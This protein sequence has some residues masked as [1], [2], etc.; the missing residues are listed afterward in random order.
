[1]PVEKH[2]LYSPSSSYLWGNCPAHILLKPKGASDD[3]EASRD[4]TRRHEIMEEFVKRHGLQFFYGKDPIVVSTKKKLPKTYETFLKLTKFEK[5]INTKRLYESMRRVMV[6][7]K[8]DIE[9]KDI[10]FYGRLATKEGLGKGIKGEGVPGLNITKA[11]DVYV[12]EKVTMHFIKR[13]CWG[14]ADLTILSPVCLYVLDYKFGFVSVDPK[15]TQGLLYLLGAWKRHLST[16]KGKKLFPLVDKAKMVIVQPKD[17]KTPLK[18]KE[19]TIRELLNAGEKFKKKAL[20]N[21]LPKEKRKAKV[22]WWCDHYAKCQ[23]YCP[24][25]KKEQIKRANELFEKYA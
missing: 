12:E 16:A 9:E 5:S 18:V 14:T 13:D 4:G 1:M 19:Y 25:Y 7:I 24:A 3:T 6:M 11:L 17:T 10:A 21:E 2:A 15:T 20:K 22:G 23:P 8:E